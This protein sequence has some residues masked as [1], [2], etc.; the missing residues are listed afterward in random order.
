MEFLKKISHQKQTGNYIFLFVV[1]LLMNSLNVLAS[2]KKF[3][4][5]K[6]QRTYDFEKVY[7]QNSIPFDEYDSSSAQFK[8]FFGLKSNQSITNYYPDL[9]IMSRSDALRAIYRSK[10]NDMI[11]NR[12]IFKLKK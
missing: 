11:D 9:N 6:N 4:F 10:L 5:R 8:S 12:F 1:F 7:F 3:Y 2:E